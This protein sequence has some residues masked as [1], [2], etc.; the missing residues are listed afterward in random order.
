M[1]KVMIQ[2]KEFNVVAL[3]KRKTFRELVTHNMRN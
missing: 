3:K 2:D 1:L